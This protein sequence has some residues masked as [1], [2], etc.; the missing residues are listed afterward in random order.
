MEPVEEMPL[1]PGVNEDEE[2]LVLMDEW[3][4]GTWVARS[5]SSINH[6]PLLIRKPLDDGG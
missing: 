5:R 2:S 6:S 1:M 4:R 3:D